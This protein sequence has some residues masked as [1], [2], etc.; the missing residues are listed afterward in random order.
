MD[1]ACRQMGTG[2][3]GSGRLRQSDHTAEISARSSESLSGVPL[4]SHLGDELR[5]DSG[6]GRTFH[7]AQD[8][9][10]QGAAFH[11]PVPSG[12]AE[13]GL[14]WEQKQLDNISAPSQ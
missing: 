10:V 4:R 5:V 8:A 3:S 11:S 1:V 13:A 7:P 12:Q 6:S 2:M 14:A 9:W